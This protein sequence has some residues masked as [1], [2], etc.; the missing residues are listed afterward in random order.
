M[1]QLQNKINQLDNNKIDDILINTHIINIIKNGEF[2]LK[3]IIGYNP[4]VLNIEISKLNDENENDKIS[5]LF[6][7]SIMTLKEYM[8]SEKD[9]IRICKLLKNN[10]VINILNVLT[11]HSKKFGNISMKN[12]KEKDLD[13]KKIFLIGD[14]IFSFI[15]LDKIKFFVFFIETY[16]QIFF[17][18]L[19]ISCYPISITS[20]SITQNEFDKYE[21]IKKFYETEIMNLN[22]KPFFYNKRFMSGNLIYYI[23]SIFNISDPYIQFIIKNY[24]ENYKKT[25]DLNEDED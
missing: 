11:L 14:K 16:F 5:Y 18:Q 24:I 8:L 6:D 3:F 2:E 21:Y 17:K 15:E 20:I 10:N 4:R 13:F 1:S 7:D 25:G 22:L 9:F 23:I 12:F 19:C